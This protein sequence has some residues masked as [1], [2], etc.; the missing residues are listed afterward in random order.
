MKTFFRSVAMCGVICAVQTAFAGSDS[1]VT[2][3]YSK[4]SNGY[5]RERLA[6]GS[7]KREYYALAKG[8]YVPG[9]G[10]DPS[11]DKV[12]YPQVAK[13]VAQFL[14]LEN[15]YLA[16]NAKSADLLLSITWGK[17]APFSDSVYRSNTDSF[18]SASNALSLA[19][20]NVPIGNG[21]GPDGIQSPAASVRDA[22]RSEFEG[23][24]YKMMM[25]E[26]ARLQADQHNA[27]LLGYVDEINYRDTP[28]RFAGAGDAYLDLWD[29]I[30][31]ERYYVII[32]AY[33]F[34]EMAKTKGE[35]PKMLW[36]TRVSVRAQGNRFNET[37]AAMLKRAAP[38]FGENT[39]RLIRRYE[40]TTKV[41]FGD[42]QFVGYES[43]P[44]KE[45]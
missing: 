28:A 13:L 36:S 11:I 31:N 1:V 3:V 37:L 22:V 12:R 35:K 15:Y 41:E 32:A 34:R 5:Q 10:A 45:R 19:N 42:L 39:G 9:V 17:T 18:F 25:F 14:A 27:R 33:D 20:R 38:Y 8:V 16:E 24:M 23:E 4:V 21:R 29:D 44:T 40:P 6:D 7:P 2:A 43:K 26:N 30:E